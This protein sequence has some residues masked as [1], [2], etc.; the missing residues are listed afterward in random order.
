[1]AILSNLFNEFLDKADA[2][3]DSLR[4]SHSVLDKFIRSARTSYRAFDPVHPP[5]Y[6]LFLRVLVYQ[7]NAFSTFRPSSPCVTGVISQLSSII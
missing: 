6:F 1:M 7:N 3:P 5:I 2:S 4:S